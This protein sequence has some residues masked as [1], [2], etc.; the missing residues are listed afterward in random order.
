MK[1]SSFR[2][3]ALASAV[4]LALAMA[5]AAHA[6]I[7][8]STI[9]GQISGTTTAQGLAVTAVN[10]ANGTTYRTATLADGTTFTGLGAG[11]YGSAWLAPVV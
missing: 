2:R 8:S 5:G 4:V 6:Q 9:K 10:L 7:A 3:H 1:H 11:A